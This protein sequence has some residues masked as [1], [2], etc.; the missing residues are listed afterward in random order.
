MN[1]RPN[2]LPEWLV[3]MPLHPRT[4]VPLV[5]WPKTKEEEKEAWLMGIERSPEPSVGI[6]TGP[7]GL[8]V[9][10]LDRKN[11]K[12]G[13]KAILDY[14]TAKLGKEEAAKVFIG[15]PHMSRT[16]SG[17]LHLYFRHPAGFNE[18]TTTRNESK[19]IDTRGM[20]GMVVAPPSPGYSWIREDWER[21]PEC[22]EWMIDWLGENQRVG[23]KGATGALTCP[24]AGS[25][26]GN[27]GITPNAGTLLR[28]ADGTM[29]LGSD[30]LANHI[31]VD[32]IQIHCPV[33][34]DITPSAV[35]FRPLGRG[36][37]RLYCSSCDRTW[38]LGRMP[39]RNRG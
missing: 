9:L 2:E 12:D 25:T 10:D 23:V 3:T 24:Q 11:G 32:K 14:L 5:D 37:I 31:G 6:V 21:I 29:G 36:R 4:K 33:H 22:P 13:L 20:G 17:G 1:Q 16:K 35:I 38:S 27:G 7:S 28:A 34:D 15:H 39:L 19:G 30:L 18:K 8:V 26:D